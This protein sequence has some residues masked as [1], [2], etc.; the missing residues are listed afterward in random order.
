MTCS[1]YLEHQ[2]LVVVHVDA[3]KCRSTLRIIEDWLYNQD[4]NCAVYYIG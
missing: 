4:I 2:L 3:I 1:L